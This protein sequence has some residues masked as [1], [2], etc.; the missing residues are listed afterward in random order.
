M[1]ESLCAVIDPSLGP[2]R[3]QRLSLMMEGEFVLAK[4]FADMSS[5]KKKKFSSGISRKRI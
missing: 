4:F 1:T 3:G 2:R 5:L